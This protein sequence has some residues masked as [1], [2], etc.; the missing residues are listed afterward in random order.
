M[1]QHDWQA[2]EA[3]C[4]PVLEFDDRRRGALTKGD[5]DMFLASGRIIGAA[6]TRTHRTVLATAGNR[7]ALEH[8]RW[9]GA[10]D[11]IP[12]ESESLSL[13]EVDADGRIVAIF[14]FD[15]D[16][17]RAAYA[18]MFERYGRSEEARGIPLVALEASR[19]TNAHD[20]RRFRAAL[21]DDF[22]L[23]DHRRT[24]LGRLGPD[25]YVAAVAALFEHAHDIAFEPLYIV[26]AEP[27]GLLMMQRAAG[28][29]AMGGGTF[30]Q[31]YA[32]LA[33]C[34]DDRV[35]GIELFEPE[36]LARA[37]ARLAELRW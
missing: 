36:D 37:R 8:V 27:H 23:S 2:R 13:A 19:A 22:V 20:L 34:K 35:V 14:G 1:E 26:A 18:E 7:L 32:L 30:E 9:R 15:V 5:R 16:D 31:V 17:R 12:F 25:E 3:L 33:C 4:A 6:G 28:T 29:L 10:D 21:A 24:G 11:A